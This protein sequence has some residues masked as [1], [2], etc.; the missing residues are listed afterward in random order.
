MYV[1]GVPITVYVTVEAF[2]SVITHKMVRSDTIT[3]LTVG[4]TSSSVLAQ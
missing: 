4:K 1:L 3:V 2:P